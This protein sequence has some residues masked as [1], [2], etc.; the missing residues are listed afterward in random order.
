MNSTRTDF[1]TPTSSFLLG[2]GT[3]L[4][5]DGK[6]FEYNVSNSTEEA[7]ALA[8]K[9]DWSIVGQDIKSAISKGVKKEFAG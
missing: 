7:D 2:M 3:V 5:I 1:L 9:S 8:I 4:N 6:F